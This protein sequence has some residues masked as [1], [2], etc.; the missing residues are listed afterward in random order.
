MTAAEPR[1]P[2]LREMLVCR[3]Q[4]RA[5]CADAWKARQA[6]IREYIWYAMRLWLRLIARGRNHTR[7]LAWSCVCRAED[8]VSV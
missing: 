7:A 5:G 3:S 8:V 4:E 2:W 1:G 6:E